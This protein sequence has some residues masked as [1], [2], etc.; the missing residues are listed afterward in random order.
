LLAILSGMAREGQPGGFVIEADREPV[1]EN[2]LQRII[3]LHRRFDA[4]M[5]VR[6]Q[7]SDA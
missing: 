1:A 6:G 4:L 3:G 7:G 2:D 5:L